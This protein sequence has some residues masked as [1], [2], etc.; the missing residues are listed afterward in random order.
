M[1]S[2]QQEG[3]KRREAPSSEWEGQ[4]NREIPCEVEGSGEKDRK[5]LL[6]RVSEEKSY[7]ELMNFFYNL[8]NFTEN[9][10]LDTTFSIHHFRP[11]CCT[12]IW[13]ESCGRFKEARVTCAPTGAKISLL[14]MQ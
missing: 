11:I 7:E 2:F 4:D 1:I 9:F 5:T 8:A 6:L 13:Y 3:K 10:N 12:C 14:F